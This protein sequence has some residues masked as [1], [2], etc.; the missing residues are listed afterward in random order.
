MEKLI[1]DT[2]IKF[3]K[4]LVLDETPIKNFYDVALKPLEE[5]KVEDNQAQIEPFV[6][7]KKRINFYYFFPFYCFLM[8]CG[9][10]MEKI[11][12]VKNK[13]TKVFSLFGR[14]EAL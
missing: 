13:I 11:L 9:W 2:S 6:V 7:S 14:R 4:V 10:I 3:E 5:A 8:G 12:G 1:A